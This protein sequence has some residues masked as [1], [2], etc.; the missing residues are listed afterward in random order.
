[1]IYILI[2]VLL[3]LIQATH[4][5]WDEIKKVAWSNNSPLYRYHN[6]IST[7]NPLLGVYQKATK[8]EMKSCFQEKE[9]DKEEQI[10]LHKWGPIQSNRL[11]ITFWWKIWINRKWKTIF[12]QR[13]SYSLY[14]T[15][16]L[17]LCCGNIAFSG[18]VEK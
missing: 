13:S 17:Q 9:I 4:T 11:D 2:N 18:K 5:L 8:P 3:C 10:G 1:M 14:Q 16:T 12:L 15:H 7:I 6:Y